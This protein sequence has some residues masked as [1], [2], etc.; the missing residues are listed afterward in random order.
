MPLIIRFLS[1]V[2]D[3]WAT[4]ITGG[5][6][7]ASVAIFELASQKRLHPKVLAFIFSLFLLSAFFQV[8]LD[9]WTA[10]QAAEADSK[11]ANSELNFKDKRI[12]NLSD[13]LHRMSSASKTVPQTPM[14]VQTLANVSNS[15]VSQNNINSP[16]SQINPSGNITGHNIQIGGTSNTINST[17]I[18]DKI[19][20]DFKVKM[21]VSVRG[22]WLDYER[23]HNGTIWPVQEQNFAIIYQGAYSPSDASIIRLYEKESQNFIISNDEISTS[24]MAFIQPGSFPLGHYIEELTNHTNLEFDLFRLSYSDLKSKDITVTEVNCTFFINGIEKFHY[25]IKPNFS[26]A[27]PSNHVACVKMIN[28]F[29]R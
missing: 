21:S 1:A 24:W 23:K 9:E 25:N 11:S 19:I 16:I 26:L 15:I 7:M 2:V 13:T 4:L 10:R 14:A 27:V 22:Q 18:E 8:W 3:H 6:V 17:E 12:S 5:V 28:G 20:R 29:F